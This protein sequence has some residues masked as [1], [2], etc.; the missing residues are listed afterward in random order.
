MAAGQV[1]VVGKW[2]LMNKV[3][4]WECSYDVANVVPRLILKNSYK[5]F[6][7]LIKKLPEFFDEELFPIF[8][9]NN[10]V[11]IDLLA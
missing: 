5:K 9:P 11:K 6:I 2:T 4:H 3:H 7:N 8:N 10:D 1:G